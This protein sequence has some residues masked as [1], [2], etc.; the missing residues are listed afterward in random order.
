M[1]SF[2]TSTKIIWAG[3]FVLL[4]VD[5]PARGRDA[6]LG[7]ELAAAKRYAGENRRVDEAHVLRLEAQLRRQAVQL[8]RLVVELNRQAAHLGLPNPEL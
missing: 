5:A 7:R 3:V 2:S 1:S 6:A 4:L 8:D